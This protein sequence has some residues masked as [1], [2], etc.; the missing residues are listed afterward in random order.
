[1]TNEKAQMSI[2]CQILNNKYKIILII[3]LVTCSLKSQIIDTDTS[4]VVIRKTKKEAPQEFNISE[5]AI[6]MD[7]EKTKHI[8]RVDL[9]I[10]ATT[11]LKLN[12]SDSS[13]AVIMYLI[14]DQTFK[15]GVYRV[16]WEMIRCIN[17]NNEECYTPGKYFCAF[18]TDQ[19]VYQKDFY[20]K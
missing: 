20:I 16:K 2:E 1:M 14:N 3:A 5:V 7:K 12:V 11:T 13:G 15:A 6:K 19:F 17:V 9:D 10:P 18:E 8:M 4:D